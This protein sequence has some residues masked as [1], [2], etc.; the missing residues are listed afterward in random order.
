MGFLHTLRAHK[1]NIMHTITLD[2]YDLT[3]LD[4]LQ[5]NGQATNAELGEIVHLSPSQVSRRLQRL[6]ETGLISG[7][8][9]LLDPAA[10]GLGVIAFAHVT[11]ERHGQTQSEAFENAV[12]A[13]PEVMEC[14]SV[15]GD[16]DYLLRIVAPDLQTFSELMMK[17]VL[18]LPGVGHIK[19]NIVLQKLKATHVLPLDHIAQPVKPRQ[20]I[21]YSGS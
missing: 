7:F 16:A 14:F 2:R 18:R 20:Q 4:A 8:A 6:T 5:R 11:L 17:R 3:L 1:T 10:L 13:L 12:T 15:S 9:A 19:S 21:R